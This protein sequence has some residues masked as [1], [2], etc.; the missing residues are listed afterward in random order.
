MTTDARIDSLSAVTQSTAAVGRLLFDGRVA[1]VTGAGRGLGRAYARSLAE[2]GAAVVVNDL[3][4][5]LDGSSS[6]ESPAKS[7]VDEIVAA[8]GRA[9]ADGNDVSTS[10]GAA[11]MVARALSEFGGLDIVINN[12]GIVN[13]SDFPATTLKDFQRH[14]GVHQQGVF[15]L[16]KAAWPQMA[17]Q[18]YGRIVVVVSSA[19][20]GIAGVIPYSSAKGG[21]LGLAKGLAQAGEGL[22]IKVNM[23]APIALTRMSSTTA[24]T[25]DELRARELA[26]APEKV[27]AVVTLLAHEKCPCNSEILVAAGDRVARMFIAETPGSI[28]SDP[29]PEN[30]LQRWPTIVAE[31]GYTVPGPAL[32]GQGVIQSSSPEV[33]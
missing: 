15:N 14:V 17:N 12:A 31:H 1:V 27:A 28:A 6:V 18:R 21:A 22:G 26:L 10:E 24:L 9:V 2:R 7:V 29:T 25:A 8:G 23:I 5:T 33:R 11:A 16:C 13:K 32:L 4:A 30:I 19:I 3:G 20:Y